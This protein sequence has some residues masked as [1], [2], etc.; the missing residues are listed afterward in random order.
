VGLNSKGELLALP[1]N[2]GLGLKSGKYSSLLRHRTNYKSR[3]VCSTGPM[4]KFMSLCKIDRFI[5]AF[6]FPHC[7][8]M[9]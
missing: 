3:D 7:A 8:E 5:V 9:V 1:S 6:D 2:I 4:S